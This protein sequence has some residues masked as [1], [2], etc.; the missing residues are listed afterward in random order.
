MEMYSSYETNLTLQKQNNLRDVSFS[1]YLN[2]AEENMIRN[3]TNQ[4]SDIPNNHHY[5]IRK[6]SEEIDVF[7]AEKYFKGEMI[8]VDH[9]TNQGFINISD[10]TSNLDRSDTQTEEFHRSFSEKQRNDQVS[11]HTPSVRS[12]ISWNSRSGLLP[13]TKQAPTK[14]EKGSKTKKFLSRFG[15]N[16]IDK[17]S[18]QI[19]EKRYIQVKETTKTVPLSSNFMPKSTKNDYF[20]FPVLNSSDLNSNTNSDRSNSNTGV[21][22]G[23]LQ[24][25]NNNIKNEQLSLGRKLSLLNDWDVD[26]PTE[27]EM[28]IP[29]SGMYN[30][31]N[32]IDSDSS[33]DLFE[34]ESFSTNGNTSF[35][36]HRASNCYAPSEVSIDWSV[37]TA[38]AADFD[39]GGWRNSGGKVPAPENK[40][41][42]KKRVGILSGCVNEK[43]VSVACNDGGVRRRRLS[44]SMAVG[45]LFRGVKGLTRFDPV[46]GNYGSDVCPVPESKGRLASQLLYV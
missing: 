45:G 1:C 12:S 13:C 21:L 24:G 5:S 33:S 9:K 40:S 41:D 36:P 19:S 39:D 14:T 38:S 4:A 10:T 17:K 28:Y 23:N 30:N 6:K 43:A 35:L 25:N 15:C 27:D 3:L 26:I 22:A 44:E 2:K 7:G 46:T 42:D 34:I 20:S 8:D 18:T 32:D 16:C 11:I 37:V 31:S 29:S